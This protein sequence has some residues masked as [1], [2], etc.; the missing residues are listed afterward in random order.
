MPLFFGKLK[1]AYILGSPYEKH[2][3]IGL[4]GC[5]VFCGRPFN[6]GGGAQRT[7]HSDVWGSTTVI[8]QSPA[9]VARGFPTLREYH[10]RQKK[11]C[12]VSEL[13]PASA[14][15]QVIDQ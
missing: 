13:P 7:A 4:G 5:R 9:Q 10:G 14:T 3:T 12:T 15:F 8:S 2:I 1:Q 11:D 6:K